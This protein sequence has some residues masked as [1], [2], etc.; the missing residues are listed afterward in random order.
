MNLLQSLETEVHEI[1]RAEKDHDMRKNNIVT[2]GIPMS[3]TKDYA[4]TVQN[5][6]SS[7]Y[8]I[9]C[10]PLSNVRCLNGQS[11]RTTA[12]KTPPLLLFTVSSF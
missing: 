5:F 6:L 8:G 3:S 9:A 10:G 1:I 2:Y 4:S 11:D 7:K 12:P